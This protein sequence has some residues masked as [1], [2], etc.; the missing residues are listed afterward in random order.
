LF[1]SISQIYHH[2]VSHVIDLQWGAIRYLDQGLQPTTTSNI[3]LL[4]AIPL[5][6]SLHHIWRALCIVSCTAHRWPMP[7]R[8]KSPGPWDL[9]PNPDRRENPPPSP[10]RLCPH[11]MYYYLKNVQI[12][13]LTRL[14]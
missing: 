11:Q 9:C 7:R 5:S 3:T 1:F 4:A 12:T 2:P 8:Q 14:L 6:C 10:A 13:Q